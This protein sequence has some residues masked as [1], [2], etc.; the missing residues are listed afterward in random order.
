MDDGQFAVFVETLKTG[1]SAAE[2]EMVVDGSNALLRN[3]EVGAELII[4]VVTEGNERVE[5]VVA[6]G[7]FQHDEDLAFRLC[8]GRERRGSLSERSDGEACA[9]SD[10]DA[11]HARTQQ[12][13]AACLG[14]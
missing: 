5:A 11:V 3:T 2:T 1:H 10:A 14:K 4:R 12:V 8:F 7:E 13:A 6:A 9:R